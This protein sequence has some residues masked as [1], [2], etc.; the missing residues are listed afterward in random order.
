MVWCFENSLVVPQTIRESSYYSAIPHLGIYPKKTKTYVHGK[1]TWMFIAALSVIAKRWM[2]RKCPLTDKCQQY[3][4][5]ME[6]ISVTKR[7]EHFSRE[8]IW[9]FSKHKKRCSTLL[10]NWKQTESMRYLFTCISVGNNKCCQGC[11][12]THCWWNV[13]WCNLFGK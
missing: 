12:E 5:I 2:Q 9:M 1:T 11:G 8:N 7:N 13:K 3:I 6:C 4:Y 10:V